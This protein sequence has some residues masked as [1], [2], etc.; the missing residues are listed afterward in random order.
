MY[1]VQACAIFFIHWSLWRDQGKRG[2][3]MNEGERK[4]GERK[5]GER[6]EG[7]RGREREEGGKRGRRGGREERGKRGRR[8]GFPKDNN[9]KDEGGGRVYL[10][11]S[12]S[13][14]RGMGFSSDTCSR[15]NTEGPNWSG[16]AILTRIPSNKNGYKREHI[17]SRLFF[18]V[19]GWVLGAR[20]GATQP[21]FRYIWNSF[22]PKGSRSD[23]V[24]A[25]WK[26]TFG[27]TN[28]KKSLNRNPTRSLAPRT[29]IMEK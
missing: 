21:T 28:K 8:K 3:R 23:G 9:Q 2:E 5:E 19:R 29:C 18:L 13:A 17:G 24:A 14:L 27:F 25:R 22:F 20:C 4:E 12:F 16:G 7:E 10:T 11:L 15:R 1:S 26:K 6:K